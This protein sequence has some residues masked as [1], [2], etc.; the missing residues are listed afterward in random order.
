MSI[1]VAK[2]KDVSAGTQPG[3]F[4]IGER[5][6]VSSLTDLDPIYRRLLDE[7]VTAIVA[8]T[9][10]DGQPN[11]TPV[12]FDYEGDTVLLNLATHRKK[13][14]WLRKTPFATFILMNPENTYHW[15]SL[16]T[17]V[18]RE[19]SE[20]DPEEG[21]RVTEQLDRIWVKYTQNDPPYGLRDPSFDER[22]VLFELQ[23][24]KV[25]TFGRP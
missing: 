7:P 19:I 10:S 8:V 1:T 3:Q 18:S 2:F 12:W 14:D 23:V 4:T 25:A 9:G 20:D 5:E 21:P 15:L 16:K 22:R 11:L 17:K 24:L 13:V 6:G